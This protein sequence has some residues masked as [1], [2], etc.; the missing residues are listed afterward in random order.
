MYWMVA[1][2]VAV[3]GVALLGRTG[4]PRPS[5]RRQSPGIS[6]LERRRVE[7]LKPGESYDT[8]V[9]LA[10][11]PNVPFADLW[12]Q[13]LQENGIE[14]FY[15]SGAATPGWVGDG[16]PGLNPSAPVELWVGKHDLPRAR[17]LFPELA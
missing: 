15:K 8:G 17:E 9:K 3:F 12:C 7:P 6:K 11:V 10:T 5:T 2:L 4:V 16:G 13:R 14:A 1:A